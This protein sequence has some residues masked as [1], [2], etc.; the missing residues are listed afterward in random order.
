MWTRLTDELSLYL[1]IPFCD[2]KCAYCD[3]NSYAGMESLIPAYT[4]ALCRE[5]RLWAPAAAGAMVTTI[6][7]GGGTPSLMPPRAMVKILETLSETYRLAIDLELSLE[8]NPG[9]VDERHLRNLRAAGFARISIGVQSFDDREL[10]AL[11]RIHSG[12]QAI[13]AYEAARAARFENINLDLIYGLAGQSLEAWAANVERALVLHPEH[14]SLYALTVEEGTALA[15]Q[16]EH[17]L[18]PSPDAD[19]QAD[20]YEL[21]QERLERAGYEQY[22]I[23]N[24]ALPGRACGHNLT[25]WHNGHWLGFG[26]GAYSS[27]G[28]Y[29]FSTT[30]SPRGYIERVERAAAWPGQESPSWEL[31]DPF[32]GMPQIVWHESIDEAM[33]MSDTAILGLRLV[34]GLSLSAFRARHGRDF[35]AVFGQELREC[36]DASLLQRTGDRV[37]L[38]KR[39]LFLANEVFTRLLAGSPDQG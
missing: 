28:G 20:M 36:Y 9:T 17:G 34:E 33:A 4:D 32:A 19:L 26:A 30:L 16:I 24:W 3:F 2:T 35:D 8:A 18:Q 1:H 22:E 10:K 39:G 29:R 21:A 37:S 14:L 27:I 6:F 38:T 15:Y 25:Y 13:A 7:F 23:S 31:Q 5:A 12:E 11:D